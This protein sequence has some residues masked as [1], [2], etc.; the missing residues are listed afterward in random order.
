MNRFFKPT[1]TRYKSQFVPTNLPA[2]LMAKTLYAKQGKADKMLAASVKLGE[3]EQAALSGRDTKYVEDIKKEVQAFAGSAMSQDRTSPEFQRKYLALTNKI[4]NDKNLTKIQASVDNYKEFNARHKELVKKGDNAAA[5][6]LE[7]DYMYRFNEYTKEGGEGFE[8]AMGLGDAN[9]IEGRSHFEDALK[10]FTPLKA[11]GGESIKFLGDGISYK[12][13]WTGVSDKRVR[14]QLDRVYNDWSNKDAFKQ[15]RLRELQK[16]GL[17]Q[18]Q[19]NALNKEDKAAIDKEIDAVQKNNFLNVGR[20]VVHGKSTTNRDQALNFGRAE[21]KEEELQVVIPTQEKVY[22]TEAS[23]ADRDK[24]IT[25][26]NN[27]KDALQKKLNADDKRVAQGLASNYT[28]EQRQGMVEQVASDNKKAKML[29]QTKNSD[30]RK[31]YDIQRAKA[32]GKF[33]D[34]NAESQKLVANLGNLVDGTTFTTEDL[35]EIKNAITTKLNNGNS[36]LFEDYTVKN[37]FDAIPI[38]NDYGKLRAT[39]SKLVKVEHSKNVVGDTA[40]NRTNAI[41]AEE[42]Q[43]PGKTTSNMQMSGSNVRTDSK[44]TMAAVNKDFLSNT[45]AYNMYDQN[46]NVVEYTSLVDFKGN[47]V[48]SGNFRDKGDFAMSGRVKLLRQQVINGVPQLD[49]SGNPVMKPVVMAVNIVPNGAHGQF[50]KNNFSNEQFE[51]ANDK[52]ASGDYEQANVART[53]ALNLNSASRIEDLNDFKTSTS[54]YTTIQTRAYSPDRRQSANAEFVV[55]KLG[56]GGYTVQYGNT[57]D[58]FSDVNEVNAYIQTLTNSTP[59]QFTK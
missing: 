42:Y 11:S 1:Q 24:Q 2:D 3:F 52:E 41:W 20:T 34:L 55:K 23:Y 38:S 51:I 13:G 25:A 9:I 15:E 47:S 14:E 35:D 37:I 44:S 49:K 19:Y 17:V 39:L 31:I 53:V 50:L 7:A 4:K 12:S 8:G 16:R 33:N 46:G 22:T 59:Q 36:I 45:E 29:R 18:T 10:F 48:T 6:E 27:S 30:Y 56:A 57:E 58:E 54:K 32:T 28:A 21:K 43:N 26:L 40:R 5:Q